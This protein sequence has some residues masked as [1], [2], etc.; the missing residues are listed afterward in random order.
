MCLL[1]DWTTF[2]I[3]T[4]CSTPGVARRCATDAPPPAPSRHPKSPFHPASR[5]RRLLP[6]SGESNQGEGKHQKKVKAKD[7]ASTGPVIV[8]SS[9]RPCAQ[10]PTQSF[11]Y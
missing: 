8:S 1:W 9:L 7:Q 3:D 6:A 10:P 11:T 5:Q 2:A 4:S